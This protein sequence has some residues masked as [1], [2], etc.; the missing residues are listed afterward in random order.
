MVLCSLPEYHT[1]SCT[2]EGQ[3]NWS[4]CSSHPFCSKFPAPFLSVTQGATQQRA[5]QIG[6]T[7]AP[8]FSSLHQVP[9]FLL[10]CHPGAAQQWGRQREMTAAPPFSHL[11]LLK[12]HTGSST[13]EGQADWDDSCS[14]FLPFLF[15]APGPLLPG[16]G[17]SEV[18]SLSSSMA[19]FCLGYFSTRLLGE[20]VTYNS[21]NIFNSHIKYL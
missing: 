5:R 12:Y 15:F 4:S 11:P 13:A 7:D 19:S 17:C 3:E 2:A 8:P 1:G 6:M 20:E 14:P 18:S 21:F 10:E 9:C 16:V